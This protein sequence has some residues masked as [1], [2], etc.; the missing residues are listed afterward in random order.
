VRAS[1]GLCNRAV[2]RR[3]VPMTRPEALLLSGGIDS[4]ALAFWWRPALAITI[5]YGQRP[6]QAEVD[7]AAAVCDDLGL[8]H[9]IVQVDCSSLGS[10]DLAGSSALPIAPI[11]EWWP[12]RNQLL[13]TLAAAESVRRGIPGLVVGT[14]KTDA[15]HAD[16]TAHFIQAM[17]NLLEL[18][19][20]G[21]TLEA[22]AI[23]MSSAELV[24]HSEIPMHVLAWAHSCHVSD[25]ACG[26]C[27]GCA[28]HSAVMQELGIAGR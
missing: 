3:V 14:V 12:F 18:Q 20:G 17:S 19:E 7:A 11:P 13:V 24:R 15:A 6:A 9:C 26:R 27:R 28:K 25:Y 8:E 22:P 2:L 5:D 23:E 21:L 4:V 1:R 10:G 16:G